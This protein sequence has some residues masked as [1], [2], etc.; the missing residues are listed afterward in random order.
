M[1]IAGLG[2]SEDTLNTLLEILKTPQKSGDF[3][4]NI[5]RETAALNKVKKDIGFLWMMIFYL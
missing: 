3:L 5:K 2:V 1:K 4:K